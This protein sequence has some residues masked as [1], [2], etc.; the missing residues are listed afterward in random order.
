MV[1]MIAGRE[2]WRH[3]SAI[4]KAIGTLTQ[5]RSNVC[6]VR[7]TLSNDNARLQAVEH[8]KEDCVAACMR[9]RNLHRLPD[10]SWAS[11]WHG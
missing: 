9:T 1:S 5:S 8:G 6:A 2:P 3:V 11:C 7:G 4:G 10:M